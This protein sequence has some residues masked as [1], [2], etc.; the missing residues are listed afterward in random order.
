MRLLKSVIKFNLKYFIAFIIL[1]FTEILISKTT[2]FIRHTFGDFLATIG[3]YVFVKSF[4]YIKPIPLAIGV[5]VFAFVVELLQLTS[6]L[7]ITG[8]SES[9]V[10]TI[11]FGNTF[12]YGDLIAYTLGVVTIVFIDK[13]YILKK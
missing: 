10:A 4:L 6:F 1:L 13:N 12:S 8:L 3:V 7:E 9:R 5:L 2:G 11:I